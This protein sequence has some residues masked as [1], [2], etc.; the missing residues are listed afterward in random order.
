MEKIFKKSLAL[1]VSAALCL[2]AF[3]G[4]LTVN[5]EGT[6]TPTYTITAQD[7][8][9][10][11]TVT[12]NVD[13]TNLT[14]V[15]GQQVF[16][17]IPS[18][19]TIASVK[20]NAGNAYVDAA[21]V[22]EGDAFDYNVVTT[23]TTKQV[24]FADIINFPATGS[25]SAIETGEFHIVFSLTIPK[26]AAV[27]D[28]YTIGFDE[29]TMFADY[30]ETEITID[31]AAATIIVQA[32]QPA[33][34][35]AN[36]TKVLKEKTDTAFVYTCSC[37]DCDTADW[38]EEIEIGA[39]F[40]GTVDAKKTISPTN[41]ISMTFLFATANIGDYTD[42]V[43]V[44]EKEAYAKGATESTIKTDFVL[45][46]DTST[47]DFYSFKYPGIAPYEMNNSI[48]CYLYGKSSENKMVKLGAV[49]N[50]SVNAY[51]KNIL[52][53]YASSTAASVMKLKTALVDLLNY[54]SY[55][56]TLG[57]FNKA[58]LANANLTE[59]EAAYGTP[60]SEYC[61]PDG[62]TWS[63]IPTARGELEG[64]TDQNKVSVSKTLN[65]AEKVYIQ[66]VLTSYAAD[67]SKYSV[68]FDYY[69]VKGVVQSTEVKPC[70]EV[71]YL[72]ESNNR[73]YCVFDKAPITTF[74][75]PVTA[76]F[77]CDGVAV[78]EEI[79]S[80]EAYV[81]NYCQYATS[82]NE[83]LANLGKFVQSIYAYG[84]SMATAARVTSYID[85]VG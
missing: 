63:T 50:Y 30:L 74:D 32:A 17:N 56:Q 60:E 19:L 24:R 15:C 28:K 6:A 22:A 27:G 47:A 12:V 67:I 49:E 76:T 34:E 48:S 26:T 31:V 77:Y 43:A 16:I 52:S 66:F 64:A 9:A 3:V 5:A 68:K 36:A 13:G 55:A 37:P 44:I 23:E 69:D 85:F 11:D 71:G 4:C 45:T 70:T 29:E 78:Y 61:T 7:G 33:C 54:G 84:R 21:K 72:N 42:Y 75:Y 58:N 46:Y 39:D 79:Y 82:S 62:T 10:G 38:E 40:T 83:N 65:P 25:D 14:S 35:H 18:D 57:N 41:D 2:T 51:V 81:K 53:T 73:F 8:K 1:M 80:V 20:D 59:T